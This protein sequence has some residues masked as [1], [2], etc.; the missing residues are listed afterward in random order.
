MFS[1]H[2][3]WEN[4]E[5]SKCC[6]LEKIKKTQKK[7]IFIKNRWDISETSQNAYIKSILRKK[8]I[9][10]LEGAKKTRFTYILRFFYMDSKNVQKTRFYPCLNTKSPYM[11]IDKLFKTPVEAVSLPLNKTKQW[12]HER[13]LDFSNLDIYKCPKMDSTRLSFFTWLKNKFSNF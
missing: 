1:K 6:F 8:G 2:L 4:W 13:P 11:V 5:V 7:R 12:F 10:F 3:W 9:P